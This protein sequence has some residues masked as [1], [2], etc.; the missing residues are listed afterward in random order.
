MRSQIILLLCI[1]LAYSRSVTIIALSLHCT[2]AI[3]HADCASVRIYLNAPMYAQVDCR[4]HMHAWK[5]CHCYFKAVH[6][7]TVHQSLT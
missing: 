5:P 6:Q 4:V 1:I 2:L 7:G 3:M